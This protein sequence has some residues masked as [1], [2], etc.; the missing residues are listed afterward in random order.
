MSMALL[1]L[2]ADVLFHAAVA[3][4]AHQTN[5]GAGHDRLFGYFVDVHHDVEPHRFPRRHGSAL[6]DH[7]DR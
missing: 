1:V 4:R 7:D 2:L 6:A 3:H 5:R